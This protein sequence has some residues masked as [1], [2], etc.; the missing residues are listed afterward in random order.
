MIICLL[1][2]FLATSAAFGE[3][4]W[5]GNV[6]PLDGSEQV[7]GADLAVYFQI[8]KDGVTDADPFAR[9]EGLA[10]TLFY[11]LSGET[12]WNA[13]PMHYNV[14]V[15]N[16]DEFMAT[17]PGSLLVAGTD[18]EVYCEGLDSTDMTTC[19]GNDQSGNPAT[20]DDPLVYHIISP[21]SIDVTVHFS[22]N[23]NG[24]SELIEPV[25]VAGTFTDWGTSPV[26]LSDPDED[27]IYE[28]A[29]VIPAG[30]S[31]HQEYKYIMGTAPSYVWEEIGNRS[32]EVDDSNPDQY[33]PLDYWN[34]RSTKPIWVVFRVDMS[35]EEVIDPYIAGSQ[36][37]LHWGWDDGWTD[38]DRIYDDGTHMDEV[39]GDGIYTTIIEFPAGTYRDIEY[40]FT[41]DGTD[42]EP[43]PPYTNHR[44]TLTEDTD[45]LWL[46]VVIFGVL[47][48]VAVERRVPTKLFVR[49]YPNPF[50]ASTVIEF[51]LTEPPAQ[52]ARLCVYDLDGKLVDVLVDGISAPGVYRVVWDGGD[53]AAGVY[54]YRLEGEGISVGGRMILVK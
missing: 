2:A 36:P 40:K 11:R 15:G 10:A 23:M 52:P 38:A 39:A 30:S 48:G 14:D 22:V 3:I 42:N 32:F 43:L 29:V 19:Q 24:V 9:G 27:G 4:G 34:N 13:I 5:C 6:W 25:S 51:G 44:F 49:N 41:T 21:T 53:A 50:N 37:P 28:G 35:A 54:I 18:V 1:C 46:P 33:L 26:E 7:E 47:E 20:E 8:W 12:S 45:T 16:N 31:R 17:I